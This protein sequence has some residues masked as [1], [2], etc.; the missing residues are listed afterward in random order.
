MRVTTTQHANVFTFPGVPMEVRFADLDASGHLNHASVLVYLEH[1]RIRYYQ[2]VAGIKIPEGL[3]SWALVQI[4][5]NY[6]AP[7][8]FGERLR[9]DVRVP[10]MR[11]S[12]AG[13]DFQLVR[14]DSQLTIADGAGV[15]VYL[16][17]STGKPTELPDEVRTRI[18]EQEQIPLRAYTE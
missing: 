2:E 3:T 5:V 12:S 1:A 9:L 13:W 17:G 16:D 4:T 14:E 18:A 7:A 8:F 10:W 15:H 11:N 6:R